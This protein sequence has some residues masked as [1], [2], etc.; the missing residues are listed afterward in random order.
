MQEM[1]RMLS[2]ALALL[3]LTGQVLAVFPDVSENQW[4][5]APVEQMAEEGILE[6]YP[7][8]TFRPDETLSRAQFLAMVIRTLRPELIEESQTGE[9]WWEPIYA[10]AAQ[11]GWLLDGSETAFATGTE[12][13]MN[14]PITRYEM[15]AVLHRAWSEVG[16]PVIPRPTHSFTD[17]ALAPEQDRKFWSAVYLTAGRAL[18]NGYPD[19]SFNGNAALTRAEGAAVVLR[20]RAC[21]WLTQ[22][23]TQIALT[24]QVL[25]SARQLSEDTW[26]LTSQSTL[27]GTVLKSAEY[28]VDTE[29]YASDYNGAVAKSWALLGAEGN[30][31]WGTLGCFRWEEDGTITR[32]VDHPVY[33]VEPSPD[34]GNVAIGCVGTETIGVPGNG[35]P[36]PA[37]DEL[38]YIAPDG[39][40]TTLLA[41]E[42]DHGLQI[43]GV[44]SAAADDLR[45]EVVRAEWLG[46]W[47]TYEYA[48]EN[49]CLRALEHEPGAGFSGYTPEEAAAEQQRLDEAGCG[50]GTVPEGET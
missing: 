13:D 5:S 2:T 38:L 33:A 7:D 22:E 40:V 39:T 12:V 45:I 20:L 30:L 3:M 36:I 46:D 43:F 31:F 24:D 14:A 17:A 47:R 18:L 26:R 34:G 10:V 37:G 4:A 6:G 8:G 44:T 27:D 21:S 11:L 16:S 50:T 49:G 42:P 41:S 25:V 19:G 9:A 29:R 28:Q 32:I 23:D 48:V 15:A 35:S 1:K